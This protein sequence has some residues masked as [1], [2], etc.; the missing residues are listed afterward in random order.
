MLTFKLDLPITR[1][2]PWQRKVTTK[3][4]SKI[5][6]MANSREDTVGGINLIQQ[7][8]RARATE[9]HAIFGPEEAKPRAGD[10]EAEAFLTRRAG[11]RGRGGW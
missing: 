4:A 6:A 7:Q 1:R 11:F 3:K 5:K 2:L 9:K 8:P 10:T